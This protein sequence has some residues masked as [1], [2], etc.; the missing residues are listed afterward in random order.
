MNTVNALSVRFLYTKDLQT[1]REQHGPASAGLVET[2]MSRRN[3]VS[4]ACEDEHGKLVAHVSYELHPHH[5]QIV[6][7]SAVCKK[8]LQ[9]LIEHIAGKLSCHRRI[10]LVWVFSEKHLET[11]AALL[12]KVH[13][14][15]VS[16]EGTDSVRCVRHAEDN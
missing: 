14:F 11:L 15:H 1:I 3:T 6:D 5:F 8:G 4:I 13:K 10:T 9:V 12:C 7:A 16:M 2:M